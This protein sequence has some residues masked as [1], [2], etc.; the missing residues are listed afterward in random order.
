MFMATFVKCLSY[1]EKLYISFKC[2]NYRSDREQNE[3]SRLDISRLLMVDM[4]CIERIFSY[5]IFYHQ[6][7]KDLKDIFDRHNFLLD[8]L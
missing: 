1:L 5:Q 4:K 8:Y 2:R 7:I 6:I 3:Q